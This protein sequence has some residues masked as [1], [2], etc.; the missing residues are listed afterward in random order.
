MMAKVSFLIFFVFSLDFVI[1]QNV[2]GFEQPPNFNRNP[3]SNV[4]SNPGAN[5]V[6]NV[7]GN[8]AYNTFRNRGSQI[9]NNPQ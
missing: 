1:S 9:E 6:N 4:I 8:S 3:S 5:S 7:I 2:R